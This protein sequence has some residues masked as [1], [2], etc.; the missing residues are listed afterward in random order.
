MRLGAIDYLDD[1]SKM[2]YELVQSTRK[3]QQRVNRVLTIGFLNECGLTLLADLA[4]V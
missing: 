4:D 3:Y 1:E 2:H